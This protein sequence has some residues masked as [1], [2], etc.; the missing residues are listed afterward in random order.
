MAM[1]IGKKLGFF[2][3]L[4]SC[5]LIIGLIGLRLT[6]SIAEYQTLSQIES[7][8]AVSVQIGALNH[9]IQVERGATAGFISSK[10]TLFADVL[11]GYRTAT[12][13]AIESLRAAYHGLGSSIA[14]PGLTEAWTHTQDALGNLEALRRKAD[15]LSIPAPEAARVY[16]QAIGMNMQLFG[17][18]MTGAAT[19]ET[20]R[21]SLVYQSI[22]NAKERTGQE[23]ALL[24]SV[25]TLDKPAVAELT[26]AAQHQEAQK[27]WMGNV[28]A[29]GNDAEIALLKE[30][31]ADNSFNTTIATCR[32]SLVEKASVGDYPVESKVWF[33]AVSER[34]NALKA[35]ED[36]VAKNLSASAHE[37]EARASTTVWVSILVSVAGLTVFILVCL[38]LVRNI[39][40]PVVTVGSVLTALA[41]GDL[42]RRAAVATQDE[43]GVMATTLNTT[44]EGL[45]GMVSGINTNALNISG[46]ADG[47]S[48]VSKQLTGNAETTSN[49]SAL[50]A[51]AATQ[52]SAS[53]STFAAGV[54]EMG[55]TVS[56]IAR[57]ASQAASVAQEGVAAAEDA[58][59]AMTRL[60]T[61]STEIGVI[62]KVITSIA[63]QTNLLALNAT[64]EAA[65][66]GEAGRGF[67]VVANE[68]KELARKT[69]E[70]T[71][72]IS[73]RVSGIQGD[74]QSAQTAL[75]R[76]TEIV[77]KIND[78]QQTIATAVEEQSAT[79]KELA[80]NIG[81]VAQAGSE[82][83]AN[84]NAVAGAAKQ[85]ATG[86]EEA[87]AAAHG[88]AKLAAELTQ[89]VARFR[90]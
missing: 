24:T 66:A 4:P 30:A 23:R 80:G 48:A 87:L 75:S 79:N 67:A 31:N 70:A 83:S 49:Q 41:D 17:H 35:V 74:S 78:L 22:L 84:V 8:S 50:A 59:T 10:K 52:I 72:D 3:V 13:S 7:V 27:L 37:G 71:A 32:A 6:A 15:D 56:E 33:D 42:T 60:G 44:L 51:A 28:L 47:L 54:E 39:V 82:I 14:L 19:I 2:L 86:A 55:A 20:A 34:L 57:N 61:S 58:N 85:A 26:L 38:K 16:T 81:Q 62:V 9:R 18:L 88:L 12:D 29:R 65:R 40:T 89:A 46:A 68:V 1:T 36:L 5:A 25:F 77:G 90:T 76:I 53:I 64:I 21:Q 73:K 63:E 11:P 45:R 69:T 43:V